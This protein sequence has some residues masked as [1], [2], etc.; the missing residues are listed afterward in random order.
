MDGLS[1]AII[2]PYKGA[3]E[4][5]WPGFSKGLAKGA[6]GLVTGPGAGMSLPITYTLNMKLA[7]AW[8][9]NI[10]TLTYV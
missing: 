2:K 5:G 10:L 1:G 6:M 7:T 8:P 9:L 3:K 4:G